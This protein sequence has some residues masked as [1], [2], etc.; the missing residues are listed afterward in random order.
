MSYTS[1]F[2]R[3]GER[4]LP[5]RTSHRQLSPYRGTSLPASYIHR[6]SQPPVL[7]TAGSLR[8]ERQP[9]WCDISNN[10]WH[11][12]HRGTRGNNQMFLGVCR[13]IWRQPYLCYCYHQFWPVSAQLIAAN[14]RDFSVVV[15]HWLT[16][17]DG[18]WKEHEK[19]IS[20]TISTIIHRGND[21]LQL[22]L[23]MPFHCSKLHA[24]IKYERQQQRD[25]QQ[26]GSFCF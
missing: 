8:K 15:N 5:S 26:D 9:P 3:L 23:L 21:S 10:Q 16:V 17:D 7:P 11:V 24:Q 25:Q 2:L 13:A 1:A 19:T 4:D 20:S 12:F 18:W 6:R 14:V 22:K